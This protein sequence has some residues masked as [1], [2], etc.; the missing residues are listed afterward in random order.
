[1]SGRRSE[2]ERGSK[3]EGE[4]KLE[5]KV[6]LARGGWRF[7]LDEV[8]DVADSLLMLLSVRVRLG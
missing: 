5:S 1:M 8:D 7:G 3:E 4:M 6:D 2:E